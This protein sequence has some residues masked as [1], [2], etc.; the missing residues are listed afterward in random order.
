LVAKKVQSKKIAA[1]KSV[2][3][4]AP[5]K[6][7]PAKKAPAKKALAKKALA[8]K[9]VAAKAPAK[10]APAKKA[11]AKK[12][13]AKKVVPVKPVKKVVPVKPSKKLPAKKVPAEKVASV[14]PDPKVTA[15]KVP[16]K[17]ETSPVVEVV[18]IEPEPVVKTVFE[19]LVPVTTPPAKGKKAAGIVKVISPRP[20]VK[21][22]VIVV[23]EDESPWTKVELNRVRKALNEDEARL[24][25]EI[26]MTE[27]GL[28][29]LIRDSGDGAGD[30]QADAGSKTFEREHEMSLANN[31]RDM[32][33]QVRQA[34]G[35][36]DDRSY[37]VCVTCGK[38]IGKLRLQ[39]FPRAT[40]CM[41]CKVAE[42]RS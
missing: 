19:K 30:D 21:T 33:E 5:A 10:K 37:G 32:L 39:A 1:K 23:R 26:A 42:E 29:D 4:K 13:A 3:A 20:V 9:T 38:G 15:K 31:A 36:I 18:V 11:P 2:A 14:K 34:L 16:A 22:P 12:I 41:S 27:Q 17:K 40:L 28:A 8:K 35:R 25:E 6:K 7:A 24:L